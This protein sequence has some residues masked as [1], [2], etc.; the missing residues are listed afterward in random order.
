MP[1]DEMG[2]DSSSEEDTTDST[3]MGESF[4]SDG[5]EDGISPALRCFTY[6]WG[7]PWW[8]RVEVKLTRADWTLISNFFVTRLRTPLT[9]ELW[10]LIQRFVQ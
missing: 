8:R 10:D 5:P 9:G 7:M 4:D 1:D 3:S 2:P 6:E